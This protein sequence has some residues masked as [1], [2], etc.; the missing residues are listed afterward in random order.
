MQDSEGMLRGPLFG[1]LRR[2][3]K[4]DWIVIGWVMAAKVL[5]LIFGAK[6]FQIIQD[7]PLPGGHGWLEIWN[8]WDSPHYLRLAQVGYDTSNV[9]KAWFYPLFP[10]TVRFV[11]RLGTGDYLVAAF[12]VSGVALFAA[13]LVLRRLVQLDFPLEVAQRTVV[14]FL[15]F[16]TAYFLHIGYTE[17]LFLALTL[18]SIFAARCERWWLA[19]ILGA[20]AWMARANGFVLLPT[21][22]VEAALQ[23]GSNKRWQWQWL[24]IA[25]IPAGFGVYLLLNFH[26]TGDPFAFL[27]MRQDVTSNSFAWP[28]VGMREAIGDLH[29]H[30]NQAEMVGVQELFFVALGFVCMVESWFKLR[31]TYA[32]W[33]TG[34][35]ILLN[36]VKFIQ[37][38]PR[39]DLTLFPIFIL[40]ALLAANRFWNFVLTMW[41]LL[42]LGL[43]ASLFVRGWWSF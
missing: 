36:C 40:F 43:F 26:V 31:P 24:W 11:A 2:V 38:Q 23:Y 42:F 41:S 25:V 5:L 9:W 15:I 6:S 27:H 1:G 29:R 34:S 8:R 37:S 7:K 32:M 30:P 10:W 21:L 22:A 16:P 3:P 14:F 19:G 28:W 13:A 33:I 17:S 20:L 4:D 35:W 12:I 18:S 39:Y